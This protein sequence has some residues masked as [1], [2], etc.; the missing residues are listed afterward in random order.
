MSMMAQVCETGP[1]CSM[2]WYLVL[3]VVAWERMRTVS[4]AFVS[5]GG[6]E[7]GQGWGCNW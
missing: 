7:I 5:E 2:A 1:T 3:M 6:R 4:F